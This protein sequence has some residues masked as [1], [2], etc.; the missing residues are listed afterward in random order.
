MYYMK[1]WGNVAQVAVKEKR[2]IC[3]MLRRLAVVYS[4]LG[5]LIPLVVWL[6]VLQ[7]ASKDKDRRTKRNPILVVGDDRDEKEQLC[8]ASTSLIL[9]ERRLI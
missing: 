8:G 4:N 2:H 3:G 1:L 9:H 5:L 6:T 7:L